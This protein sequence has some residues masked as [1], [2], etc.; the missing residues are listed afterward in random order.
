MM[1]QWSNASMFK[2]MLTSSIIDIQ[3]LAAAL[4]KPSNSALNSPVR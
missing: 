3:I 1:I 4:T 2:K